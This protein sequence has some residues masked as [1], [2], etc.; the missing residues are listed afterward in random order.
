MRTILV[1]S[2]ICL[3]YTQMG[4]SGE[5]KAEVI[6]EETSP[7]ELAKRFKDDPE[8]ARKKYIRNE[9]GKIDGKPMV[10]LAGAYKRDKM[11]FVIKTQVGIDV[12]LRAK[13]VTGEGNGVQGRGFVVQFEKNRISIDCDEVKLM[14][15]AGK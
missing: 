11:V 13:K 9:K 1:T 10:E 15:F 8:A 2:L 6:V 7:N 4:M 3:L 5:K 14:P 12:E